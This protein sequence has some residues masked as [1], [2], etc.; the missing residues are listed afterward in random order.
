VKKMPKTITNKTTRADRIR[1]IKAGLPKYYA[2]TTL[3]LGGTSY[4]PAALQTFL[5]AD[6]DANDASTQARASWLNTVKTAQSTD[7][8][9]DPVLRAIQAQVQSQYG[10]APNAETV[11]ADFGYTPRKKATKTVETKAA[12]VAKT[13][14]TRT[15]RHTMGSRQKAKVH[16]TVPA[17]PAADAQPVVTTTPAPVATSSPT[18]ESPA[19]ASPTA[20]ANKSSP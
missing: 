13:L 8:A 12:A 6:I 5:Q 18:S 17:A 14:A 19:G 3:V 4:Q 1:K 11:L 7:A 2:N 16:G 15:A 9:T 10:E 20:P